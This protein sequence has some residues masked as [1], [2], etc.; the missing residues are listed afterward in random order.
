LSFST[1][2]IFLGGEGAARKAAINEKMFNYLK[3]EINLKYM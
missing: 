3:T 2:R 1:Q